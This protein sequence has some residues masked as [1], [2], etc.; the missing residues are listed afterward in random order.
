MSDRQLFAIRAQDPDSSARRGRLELPRG[1][2]RT[3]VFMPVGT[4]GAVKTLAAH[5]VRDLGAQIIL[6]NT[7]HLYLRPGVELVSQFGGL[8]RFMDWSGP[9]LTDSGGYQ[10]FSLA[11]MRK[12]DDMGVSFQS[13]LDGSRHDF[14][15]EKIIDIQRGLGSDLVMVLDECPPG[16][17]SPEAWRAAVER[18]T[19]WAR[20]SLLRFSETEPQYGQPQYPVCIVQGG[21]DSELRR[22]SAEELLELNTPVYAVGGLAVGEPKQELFDTLELLDSILPRDRPRYL[23]GVGTPSDLVR[24]VARGMDM[25]DCVMP[26]RNARNGQLFTPGGTINIRNAQYRDDP[27]PVQE[28]CDCQLCSRFS[29][30]YLRHLFNTGEVLGLRLATIHNLKFY[31]G[32]M[33]AIRAALDAGRFAP[34]SHDFLQRYEAAGHD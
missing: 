6:G 9:L 5:E 2:V 3:P 28:D 1:T 7:Y 31:L 19:A 32:L 10:I 4:H 15:P 18:T 25:F 8:H 14:T 23:M 13:H 33:A 11:S 34:W 17:A 29:R 21:T 30:A 22:R 20:R 16:D 24:S 26:T 27:A 12:L